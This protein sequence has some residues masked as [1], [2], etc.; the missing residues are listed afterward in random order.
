[1]S[2]T[3][4]Y[5]A[6]T[7]AGERVTG[8]MRA[9]DRRAALAALRERMLIPS[10]LESSSSAF[11]LGRLFQRSKPSERLAF[12][13]AYAALEQSGVDFST[14]LELLIAQARTTRMCDAL[15]S[16]RADVERGGEK[17]WAAMSHRPDEFSDLEVAM[18]AAGE[19]A[20]NR[21]QIFDRLATF[22]ERDER[23]RKRV[24][25]ALLYP[26]I[27]V[28][29][30]IAIALYL[31]I[32]VIP[33]FATLFSSF[34]V[35]LSPLMSALFALAQTLANPLVLGTIGL[36]LVGSALA[37]GSA[38]RTP[39]GALAFDALRVRIPVLGDTIR[40]TILAR[41]C[42]VLAT[43]LQ[44]GVNLVR[45]LEVAIPVAE[46]PLF[47]RAVEL[48]RDRIAGGT[49]ASLDEALAAS[50]QF[51]P[52]I[53]GFVRVGSSAGNVP[54]MLVKV[55]ELYEE[56]VESVLSTLPTIVQT[57]VTLGLGVVVGAIVYVVYVPLSTLS[58]SIR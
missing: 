58:T 23:L 7:P 41:L 53:L 36:L 33:Q 35:P 57:S 15:G 3:Y 38:L 19:E 43:L 52:L 54:H 30:A 22:L 39:E 8:T 9:L 2:V 49:A 50:G 45:A 21:E 24:A 47:A 18:V 55:A 48:S 5:R 17:L 4:A 1:M 14:A 28:V 6:R 44:S 12:F 40:K 37:T 31:F 46:S 16:I 13:R 25:A 51:P 26:A 20:G 32:A 34:G 42:R 29:V 27:V 10:S 56:D 11:S